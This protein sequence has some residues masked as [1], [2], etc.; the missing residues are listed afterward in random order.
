MTENRGL[1]WNRGS[2]TL[3]KIC[4]PQRWQLTKLSFVYFTLVAFLLDLGTRVYITSRDA[5]SYTNL[6]F[7][8]ELLIVLFELSVFLQYRVQRLLVRPQTAH[9]V[10]RAA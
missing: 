2:K 9:V 5:G 1:P 8:F 4:E 10:D 7:V 3:V 6:K